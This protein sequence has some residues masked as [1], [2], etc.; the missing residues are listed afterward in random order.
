VSEL[1]KAEAAG[2]AAIDEPAMGRLLLDLL[3][4]PSITGTAAESELQHILAE[5]LLRLGLDVDLWA[6]DLNELAADPGFPGT[7]APR[8]EAWGLVGTT[9]EAV[10]GPGLILQGHVDVVPPGDLAQWP[11]DPFSPRVAG[12]VIHGR[13]A[14]DMKAGLAANLAAIAAIRA[15]G[16]RLRGRLAT[17]C[18]VSE[19]DGG[20]G[21]FGTLR[22]GHTGDAC[23]ITEP[24][25]STL[26]TANGGALTFEL[27]V[28]GSATHGST[29]WA[30]VSA[31]DAYLPIHRALAELERERNVSVDPLMAEC[32]VAYCISVGIVR[33]GDWASS[34]PDLLVAQG[35]LGVAIDES[36]EVARLALEQ[37]VADACQRDP[38]LS[39]HPATVTWNGGK[40]GSGRL[41]AGHPLRDLV[42][43][44]HQAATGKPVLR[45]RGAPYGSDL[46]LYAEA[47]IPTLHYGPGD[48]RNAHSPREQVSMADVADVTRTLV[49]TAIRFLGDSCD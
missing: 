37:C 18:V 8:E 39:E 3:A 38:W 44:A 6:M 11:A 1:T 33:A 32:D 19:E 10:D 34:V 46:R 49:L 31:L 4:V 43:D 41:P 22:R 21:A 24:T 40:F 36:P 15:S 13:G 9:P 25:S 23:I 42:R 26:T 45:E 5:H 7:E 48:V 47:G 2:L 20:L 17:H 12:E 16:V 35:R 30:G 14:C 27:R 28:P 29:R